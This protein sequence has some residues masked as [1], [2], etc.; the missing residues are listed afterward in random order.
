MLEK[1]RR[2]I[3][4][5]EWIQIVWFAVFVYSW[6]N[7]EYIVYCTDTS[8]TVQLEGVLGRALHCTYSQKTNI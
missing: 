4:F 6:A 8:T 7:T 1:S 5:V 2:A 3:L